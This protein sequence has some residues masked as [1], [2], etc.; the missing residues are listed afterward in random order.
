MITLSTHKNPSS[1]V[2]L[3][4]TSHNANKCHV[5][6]FHIH[7]SM[8]RRLCHHVSID[9]KR[10]IK[11]KNKKQNLDH[12]ENLFSIILCSIY[13]YT[14]FIEQECNRFIISHRLCTFICIRGCLWC[15]LDG[16]V[17]VSCTDT[18]ANGNMKITT[19][20]M[21]WLFIFQIYVLQQEL[22][23]SIHNCA[24]RTR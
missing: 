11:R 5:V 1:F 18:P 24:K 23:I 12:N 10:K 17:Y 16:V 13:T 3:C 19:M 4:V 21:V 14:I 2:A 7:C 6:Y 8:L 15:F 20:K 22:H 9:M